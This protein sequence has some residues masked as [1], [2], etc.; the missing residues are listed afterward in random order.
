M[1]YYVCID[2]VTDILG[3]GDGVKELTYGKR[4]EVIDFSTN[5]RTNYVNIINDKGVRNEYCFDRFVT[6]KEFREL[7]I[8][9]LLDK[10]E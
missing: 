2:D 8:K 3:F 1:I 5:G 6:I 7:R 4:Y 9:K 10:R